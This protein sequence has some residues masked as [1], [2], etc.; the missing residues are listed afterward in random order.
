MKGL[1][2]SWG[3]ARACKQMT[4][5]TLGLTYC[6]SVVLPRGVSVG[7]PGP[8]LAVVQSTGLRQGPLAQPGV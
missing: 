5:W 8:L 4:R 6:L 3:L 1:R 7:S 2:K